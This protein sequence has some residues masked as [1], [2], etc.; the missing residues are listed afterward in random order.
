M[1]GFEKIGGFTSEEI[2]IP[3]DVE[4]STY[5]MIQDEGG[6]NSFSVSTKLP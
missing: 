3:R 6:S 2:S 4:Y 1:D 5:H